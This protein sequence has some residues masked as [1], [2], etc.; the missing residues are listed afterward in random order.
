[1]GHPKQEKPPVRHFHSHSHSTGNC[2]GKKKSTKTCPE[3]FADERCSKAILDFPG[4]NGGVGRG[5]RAPTG[6]GRG[7][8]AARPRSGR[9]GKREESPFCTGGGGREGAGRGGGRLVGGVYRLSFLS[10]IS[11]QASKGGGG[12]RRPHRDGDP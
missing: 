8:T 4:N 12:T 6:G 11:C 5:Q 10:L 3:L 1:M 7:T 2:I 9:R